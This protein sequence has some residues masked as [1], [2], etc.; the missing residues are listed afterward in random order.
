MLLSVW[1]EPSALSRVV[2][3]EDE[4]GETFLIRLQG[5][6]SREDLPFISQVSFKAA[7]LGS[8]SVPAPMLRWRSW[9]RAEWCGVYSTV[10][11][12]GSPT[13]ASKVA[14]SNLPAGVGNWLAAKEEP[15]EA[16]EH[17]WGGPTMTCVGVVARGEEGSTRHFHVQ[18]EL[19][20]MRRRRVG[21][22][23]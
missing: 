2:E 6:Q 22:I 20:P 14:Q 12:H 18:R 10:S 21:W 17:G 8:P 23:V 9:R 13:G 16:L 11:S 1:E 19:R 7:S 4:K 3:V 15:G 5:C